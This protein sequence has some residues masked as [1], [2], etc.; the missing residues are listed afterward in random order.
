[1]IEAWGFKDTETATKNIA[2]IGVKARL[3]DR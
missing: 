2:G 1:M 3:L